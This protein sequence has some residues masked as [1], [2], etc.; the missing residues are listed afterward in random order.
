M[1]VCPGDD[2]VPI[3]ISQLSIS[4]FGRI[5]APQAQS[6]QSGLQYLGHYGQINAEKEKRNKLLT[7]FGQ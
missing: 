7:Y 3:R 1:A 6:K 5:L 2:S 4:L